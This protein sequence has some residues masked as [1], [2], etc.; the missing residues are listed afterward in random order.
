MVKNYIDIYTG[1]IMQLA[2]LPV[3]YHA[4]YSHEKYLRIKYGNWVNRL[5]F[6]KL[7]RRGCFL[8]LTYNESNYDGLPHYDHIQKFMKRV[9]RYMDYHK[10]S[11]SDGLPLKY[12][13]AVENGKRTDRLH[14]HAIIFGLPRVI[15]LKL[16]AGK[17]EPYAGNLWNYGFAQCKFLVN[18]KITYICKYL[19]KQQHDVTYKTLKSQGIGSALFDDRNKCLRDFF[20]RNLTIELHSGLRHPFRV[21]RIYRDRLFGKSTYI[22]KNTLKVC[23]PKSKPWNLFTKYEQWKDK[24]YNSSMSANSPVSHG[25]YLDCGSVGEFGLVAPLSDYDYNKYIDNSVV[26]AEVN[27]RPL[28][29][30]MFDC[31]FDSYGINNYGRF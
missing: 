18:R 16:G 13:V 20:R 10:I 25:S 21:P 4:N 24:V 7:G 3:K 6:E 14:Y 1:E 19:F 23:F 12:F 28:S 11:T 31:Y 27:S 22:F 5:G 26:D 8:T 15:Q 17:N 29:D 2:K 30:I 9:R